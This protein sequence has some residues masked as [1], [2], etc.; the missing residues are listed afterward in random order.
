MSYT[1]FNRRG[2]KQTLDGAAKNVLTD[3]A[4]IAATSIARDAPRD[5]LFLVETI[6]AIGVDGE[7]QAARHEQRQSLKSGQLVTRDSRQAPNLPPDTAAV[8]VGADYAM[9]AELRDPFIWPSIEALAAVLDGV[10][11]K[12][13]V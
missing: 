2:V 8:H 1:R 13:S 11:A 3:L 6:E 7:G 4:Q 10:V 5:S 9:D 12:R